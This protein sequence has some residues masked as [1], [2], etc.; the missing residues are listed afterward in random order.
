MGEA[1]KK[2]E[3]ELALEIHHEIAGETDD[4][5]NLSHNKSINDIATQAA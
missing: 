5:I 1:V 2:E 4:L 3:D